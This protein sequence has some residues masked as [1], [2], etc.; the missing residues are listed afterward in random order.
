MP[1]LCLSVPPSFRSGGGGGGNRCTFASEVYLCRILNHGYS[2]WG[3]PDAHAIG[4]MKACG[5]PFD[6]LTLNEQEKLPL[7]PQSP[8][9][10]GVCESALVCVCDERKRGKERCMK[11]F[12]NFWSICLH[13]STFFSR[14]EHWAVAKK[15]SQQGAWLTLWAYVHTYIHTWTVV[16][17][18]VRGCFQREETQEMQLKTKTY[19]QQNQVNKKNKIF[20]NNRQKT[21][22]GREPH[23]GQEKKI[24]EAFDLRSAGKSAVVL[25]VIKHV[26][27]LQTRRRLKRIDSNE[28]PAASASATLSQSHDRRR[29]KRHSWVECEFF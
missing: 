20:R 11:R 29:E 12:T 1:K 17:C 24:E 14:E 3:L 8:A 7:K 28:I 6:S 25:A 2:L 18:R 13:V 10:V 26:M 16:S 4:T 19:K 22:E 15:Y 9:W 21:P 27:S 5:D 23:S